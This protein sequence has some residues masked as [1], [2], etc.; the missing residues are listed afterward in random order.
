M[1]NIELRKCQ[2]SIQSCMLIIHR[3]INIHLSV[4]FICLI[5]RLFYTTFSFL[6][7][8]F[9][10]ILLGGLCLFVCVFSYSNSM[11]NGIR[12][13]LLILLFDYSQLIIK[14]TIIIKIHLLTGFLKF[15]DE[16]NLYS[17]RNI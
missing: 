16:L 13:F 6:L 10:S 7:L 11:K 15:F 17:E 1:F 9:Y 8:L 5:F 4:V 2:F 3:C 12:N 14:V